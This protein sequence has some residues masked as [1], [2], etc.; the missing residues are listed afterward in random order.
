MQWVILG[1]I[2]AQNYQ[3]NTSFKKQLFILLGRTYP[4]SDWEMT[5]Q[6][7]S[8]V[9]AIWTGPESCFILQSDWLSPSH[10]FS[11]RS[12][13]SLFIGHRF[14]AALSHQVKNVGRV[15][16]SEQIW[17]Q[18]PELLPSVCFVTELFDAF[19][20]GET[21]SYQKPTE[22]NEKMFCY[23]NWQG[24]LFRFPNFRLKLCHRRCCFE[25]IFTEE[26]KQTGCNLTN[27]TH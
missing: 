4:A 20:M 7:K 25:S 13:D 26:I 11:Q 12:R 16:E 27:F 15:R 8:S 24:E 21:A 19:Q 5:P 9:S 17:F 23:E 10:G 1:F 14:G 6:N 3:A 22:L 2:L 18:S